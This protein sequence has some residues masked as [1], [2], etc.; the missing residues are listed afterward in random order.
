MMRIVFAGTPKF[1]ADHLEALLRAP[2]IQIVGVVTQP[3]KPG[4]RGKNP[5]PSPV[6][7]LAVEHR[8]PLYQPERLRKADLASL[9]F[10]LLIVV[11]YGQILR[12]D[13]LSMPLIAPINVHA[14]LLPRWRGA[15]PIQHA[16]LAGDQE[17]GVSIMRMDEGLDT[18]PI[19]ATARCRIASDETSGSLFEKL[20]GIG[21]AALLRAI[22][23]I[24]ERGLT[25]ETQSDEGICYASKITKQ[26]GQIN[27]SENCEIIAR[28]IRA[29]SPS[30]VAFSFL[31][32]KRVRVFDT[33]ILPPTN[34]NE[35]NIVPGTII[36]K[37]RSGLIV[38]CGNGPICIT[39]LQLPT[40]KGTVLRGAAIKNVQS[41]I[42]D[43]GQRF[44]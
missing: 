14:S 18:G 1:A 30:P 7:T 42:L 35:Q 10:D 39:A 9:T 17:T 37:T 22:K 27:W 11:A 32:D 31:N 23:T 8:L 26:A 3:D 20:S 4:K 38:E 21:T 6:K 15:A 29:F 41:S 13:L 2:G 5:I 12:A 36:E 25:V 34:S 44:Q 43:P 24:S 28:Q 19:I 16:I 40:G 33:E